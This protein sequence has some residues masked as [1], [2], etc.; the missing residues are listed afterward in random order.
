MKKGQ[1][2]FPIITLIV[3]IV[4]LLLL[5]PILMKIVKT[6][7]DKFGDSL[8][9]QSPEAEAQIDG[10]TEHFTNWWDIVIMC[11]FLFNVVLLFI[12]AF[13]VD[14][15]PAFILI[16]LVIAFFTV[17]FAP[18]ML[19][20]LEAIWNSPSFVA[21][22]ALLPYTAFILNNFGIIILAT[23]VLSGIIMYAKF[24]YGARV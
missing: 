9:S 15:H 16:Y 19:T 14:V 4:V 22:T 6:S 24:K 2:D 23:I 7:T 3:V 5:S 21:E 1:M 20:A 10:I 13:L 8:S 11:L 12:S 17:L 18:S